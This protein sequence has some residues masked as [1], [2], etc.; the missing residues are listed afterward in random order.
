MRPLHRA[1]PRRRP[2]RHAARPTDRRRYESYEGINV[3]LRYFLRV[4]VL[5]N[6]SG[7]LVH[8][9]TFRVQAA[10]P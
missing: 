8:E 1:R 7:K 6:Y 2:A 5:R 10:A 4:T 9:E 3:R